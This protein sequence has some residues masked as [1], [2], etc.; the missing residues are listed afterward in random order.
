MTLFS[1]TNFYLGWDKYSFFDV[2]V[3]L[4]KIR[5]ECGGHIPAR[6]TH[7]QHEPPQKGHHER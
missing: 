5:L 1:F 6:P 3:H 7:S 2:S 4:G